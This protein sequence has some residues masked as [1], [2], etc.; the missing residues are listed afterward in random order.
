MSTDDA[1]IQQSQLAALHLPRDRP[2]DAMRE[3]VDG[4]AGNE[5][6]KLHS[7]L[8]AGRA[9]TFLREESDLLALAKPVEDDHL[10]R[11]LQ[12]NWIFR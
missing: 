5:D 7:A 9:R 11:F 3:F 2:L 1:L 8:L 6:V 12:D 4:S 10:S